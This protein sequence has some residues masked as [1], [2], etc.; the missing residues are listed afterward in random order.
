MKA[1][2]LCGILIGLYLPLLLDRCHVLYHAPGVDYYAEIHT[3]TLNAFS[4]TL[5][6]PFTCYGILLWFPLMWQCTWQRYHEI[7]SCLYFAFMTYYTGIDAFVG[8]CTALVY[9]G[10]LFFA[11]R[12][13]QERFSTVQPIIP[14]VPVECT[15]EYT[16]QRWIV[17]IHGMMVMVCALVFQELVGHWMSGDAC[18]RIEG[19]PN[20]ILHAMYYSVSHMM[21]HSNGTFQNGY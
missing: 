11:T 19:I 9:M 20:A 13:V 4:H 2:A 12:L 15:R 3:T 17:A 21:V 6:M 14:N 10:P 16:M 1:G 5:G 7:Q 8:F 18:S